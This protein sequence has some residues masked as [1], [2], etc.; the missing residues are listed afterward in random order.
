MR[1]A[2]FIRLGLFVVVACG[3]LYVAVEAQNYIDDL[4]AKWRAD[5]TGVGSVITMPSRNGIML[6]AAADGQTVIIHIP[7]LL[8]PVADPDPGTCTVTT[9]FEAGIGFALC[10]K[11]AGGAY[12]VSCAG[13]PRV[14]H[15]LKTETCQ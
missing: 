10:F 2:P 5:Q 15:L 3:A 7:T 14:A 4:K 6:P 8:P 13:D 11:R 1:A 9:S 12:Q